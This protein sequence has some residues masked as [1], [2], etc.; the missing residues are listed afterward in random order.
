M[1]WDDAT[2]ITANF[3]SRAL[4]ALFCGVTNEEFKKISFMKVV[5]EAWTILET[6]YKGTKVVKT[7]KVQQL[8]SSFEEI[9]MEEDETFDEF[10]A[11]LK[12][13][14]NSTFNLGE[15][16][17][18]SKV[19]RKILR[20]LLE[21]FY[22]KIIAIEEVKDIDQIPLTE[23]VGNFQTYKM[24]LGSMGKSGKS[25]NLALKG[26]EEKI[27]D[28]KDEDESENED[29][30]LIF[31]SDEII[32][33]LQFRKKDKEC[34]NYLMKE[35]TNESKD[36][37]L[38]ATLSDIEDDFSDEFVDECRHVMTFVAS[39]DK[40]IVES[41]SDSEDSFDD[42]VSK[43]MALQE[44]Y[45]KLCTEFIKSGK[46][47]HF[48]RKELNEVK[49]EKTDLLVKLDETT[50]LVETLIVE[51]AS[52]DEKSKILRLSKVKLELK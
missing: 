33:L 23:L 36:K 13:I 4:N 43:K 48:C 21:R 39:T 3:N 5:K 37:G 29:E 35:K 11:K 52:L 18:E 19:V 14:M 1:D 28:S 51:N 42:E 47:S 17:A 27:D 15:C 44:A 7:V 30:D 16:I 41:A 31:I 45:D 24:G 6:T 10:Y 46:T 50:R 26:I 40:V 2:I 34:P 49:T 22:A 12:D 9:K 25:K 8:T 20:S 32:K 38:V